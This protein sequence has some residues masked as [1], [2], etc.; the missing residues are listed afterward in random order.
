MSSQLSPEVLNALNYVKDAAY[1]SGF[2]L[3][4]MSH[5]LRN[6]NLA[7]QKMSQQWLIDLESFEAISQ[8]LEA[9]RITALA[10][11]DYLRQSFY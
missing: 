2:N 5:L 11:N 3:Q 10:P 4:Y 1:C 7:G 9:Q 8:I 6:G